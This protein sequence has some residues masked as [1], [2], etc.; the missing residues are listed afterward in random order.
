LIA[1]LLLAPSVS[2][3][4]CPSAL[5]PPA[6]SSH[7]FWD[8]SNVLLFSGVAASRALD[9]ASTQHFRARGNNEILLTNDIVDNKPLFTGI[10]LAGVALSIGVSAWLHHHDHHKLERWVSIVHIGVTT[11]GAVRNYRLTPPAHR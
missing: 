3:S 7:A 10:E 9:F 8:K 5:E 2:A 1:V 11:F 4:A 6:E